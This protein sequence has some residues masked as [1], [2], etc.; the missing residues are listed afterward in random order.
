MENPVDEEIRLFDQVLNYVSSHEYG[1]IEFIRRCHGGETA[2]SRWRELYLPEEEPWEE[3]PGRPP[4]P[5]PR[6]RIIRTEKD[7]EKIWNSFRDLAHYFIRTGDR[8]ILGSLRWLIETAFPLGSY[9]SEHIRREE[10]KRQQLYREIAGILRR[11]GISY[12][13]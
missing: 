8:G 13:G 12:F 4:P 11:R 2:F 3:L 1:K 5:P 7:C 9:P 6:Q 10:I